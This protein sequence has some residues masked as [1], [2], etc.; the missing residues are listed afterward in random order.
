MKI[1][2]ALLAS[3]AV[4]MIGAAPCHEGK[5]APLPLPSTIAP[6]KLAAYEQE[7]LEWLKAGNYKCWKADKGIRDTGPWI[8]D[9]YYGTHK[10]AKIYYSPA[11][12]KWLIGGRQGAIPDG[13]MIIKEQ[14]DAPAARWDGTPPATV[15]DWTIMIKDSKGAADGWF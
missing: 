1:I 9:V 15:T 4:S 6:E 7:I 3:I 5:E 13:A 8:N 2:L 10:A 14:F 12:M 11:V